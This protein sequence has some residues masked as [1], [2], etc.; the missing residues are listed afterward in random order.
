M[1]HK[2]RDTHPANTVP[3]I[4]G[5]LLIA[6]TFFIP[7]TAIAFHVPI[8]AGVYA[9]PPLAILGIGLSIRK[10]DA[11]IG[12]LLNAAGAILSILLIVATRHPSL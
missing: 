1:T 8:L 4:I 2:V 10:K 5:V 6:A 7:A 9:V 11:A 12:I 3:V